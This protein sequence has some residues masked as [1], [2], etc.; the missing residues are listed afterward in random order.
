MHSPVEVVQ[1]SD[2]HAAAKLIAEYALSLP[3]D[4][5]FNR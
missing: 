4:V 3:A 5:D 1:I 2:I